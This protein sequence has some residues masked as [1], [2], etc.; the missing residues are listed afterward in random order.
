MKIRKEY[1][2]DVKTAA[3]ARMKNVMQQ[4]PCMIAFSGGKESLILAHIALTL[5][6][7]EQVPAENVEVL[8]I[9]EEAIFPCIEKV[10]RDWR[11]KFT[12]VGVK[13]TWVCTEFRHYS[14][15]N[16]L[17][18][19]ESFITFDEDRKDVWVRPM[20]KGAIVYDNPQR[21]SYQE[22]MQKNVT[23]RVRII[24]IRSSESVQRKIAISVKLGGNMVYPIHDWS[25]N[26]VWLYLKENQIEIPDAYVNMYKVGVSGNRLRISQFFSIDTAGS[27][28][29]MCEFYPKLYEKILRREPNAYLAM[30]YW[31][32]EMF[33]RST[34]KRQRLE[35]TDKKDWS[36]E[37]DRL[38]ASKK[39]KPA[40]VEKYRK[41]LFKYG[42]ML[43]SLPENKKNGLLKR[44]YGMLTAGDPKNRT[45][46]AVQM[47]IIMDYAKRN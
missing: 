18:N 10:V 5:V 21:L 4:N 38:I 12:D 6:K 1:D 25:L 20:E 22:W 33:R 45:I 24:G 47:T 9:D 44:I 27:L 26:D 28:V 40:E 8:F 32:T 41:M 43:K 34:K 16:S 14:C 39:A 42:M 31:D 36:A 37:I 11:K 15:F 30:M 35:D 2:F 46:R 3:F 17:T 19:D 23:S 29:R 7:T 13:F